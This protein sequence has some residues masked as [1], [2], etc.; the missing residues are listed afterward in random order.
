MRQIIKSVAILL[1]LSACQSLNFND[2]NMVAPNARLLP[3]MEAK[4][5]RKALK[6]NFDT[7]KTDDGRAYVYDDN[8]QF[9]GATYQKD[10]RPRDVETVFLRNMNNIAQ[11]YGEKKGRVSMRISNTRAYHSGYYYTVPSILTL[12]LANLFG[13][14]Y[15]YDNMD[16]ELEVTITD[17]NG[18]PVRKYVEIGHAQTPVAM[19]YGYSSSDA[20]VLSTIRATQDALRKINMQIANDFDAINS[21]LK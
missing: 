8:I 9:L 13:M 15:V 12:R 20:P 17:K 5:S 21:Q 3:P 14:P 4:I 10:R 2:V 6:E 1:L 18:N 16:I 11:N 7:V 19:Y